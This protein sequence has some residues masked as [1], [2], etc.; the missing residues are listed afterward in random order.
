MFVLS[1]SSRIWSNFSMI[2]QVAVATMPGTQI[3]TVRLSVDKERTHWSE[4]LNG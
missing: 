3:I 4:Q 1:S 2:V